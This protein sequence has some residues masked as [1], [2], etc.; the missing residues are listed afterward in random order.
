MRKD[1]GTSTAM[2]H[3]ICPICGNRKPVSEFGFYYSKERQKHRVQNYCK[4]CEKTEKKQR[5]K[6]YYENN[7]EKRKQYAKDYRAN[8]ANDAQRKGL[9]QHFKN[10]YREELQ[11]CYVRDLLNQKC[12]IPNHVSKE[13]P[14][15]VAA[16]RLQI[17]IKRK[18]KTLKDAKK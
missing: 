9:E 14:E 12:G 1:N 8:P 17:K 5:S 4:E 11:D 13:L 16:K 15:I 10:K 2:T 18:I 3:K 7:T 6:I